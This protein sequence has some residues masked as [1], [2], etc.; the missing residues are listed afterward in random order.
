MTETATSKTVTHNTPP[1]APLSPEQKKAEKEREAIQKEADEKAEATA[2][3]EDDFRADVAAAV[4]KR[5]KALE[6]Y[7]DPSLKG[8]VCEAYEATKGPGDPVFADAILEYRNKLE[9]HADSVI[10]TGLP[11]A[12]T[13]FEKKV[14]DLLGDK[15]YKDLANQ[16]SQPW[17]TSAARE[18]AADFEGDENEKGHLAKGAKADTKADAKADA[19]ASHK[20]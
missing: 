7:T 14:A 18:E 13:D 9:T 10:R 2:K 3:A 15:R 16:S 5:R 11:E 4:E 20:K 12:P 8:I 1:V 19:T 6:G 17:G